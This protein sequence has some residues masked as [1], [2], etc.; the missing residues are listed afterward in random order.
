MLR[1]NHR[2]G[3]IVIGHLDSSALGELNGESQSGWR[4]GMLRFVVATLA[5]A[6]FSHAAFAADIPA[7]APKV[8][9]VQT[10]VAANPVWSGWYAGI[11]GGYGWAE[12]EQ[13][14]AIPFSS[15]R[16]DTSGGLIGATLGANWQSGSVVYGLETDLSWAKIEGSTTGAGSPTGPCSGS[17]AHCD[18]EIR[19]LGS[20]RGRIGLA[21]GNLLPYITGGLAYADVR[22]SEGVAGA[23]GAGSKWVYGWTIGTGLEAV[24]APQWTGKVE[25]LYVDLGDHHVFNDVFVGTTFA[26]NLDITAHILRAGLNYRFAT[27]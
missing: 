1:A 4:P 20:A 22:G 26:E 19:A 13:T 25:Y 11:S 16:Y 3:N 10:A 7:K 12:V 21:W 9:S 8:A 17:P 15:G 24:L 5:A 6:G 18:S 2:A 23:G 14:D 27:W